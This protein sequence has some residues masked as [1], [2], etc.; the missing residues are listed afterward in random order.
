MDSASASIKEEAIYEQPFPPP[1]QP[2]Q[3]HPCPAYGETSM[4]Q[5]KL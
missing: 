2:T 3:M 4:A 1:P 5:L